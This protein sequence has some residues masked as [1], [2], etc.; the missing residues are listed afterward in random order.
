MGLNN[1]LEFIELETKYRVEGDFLY[2][3][4]NLV[5]ELPGLEEFIYVESKDVYYVNKNNDFVRYR[6]S[7]NKTDKRSEITWKF[8]PVGALNNIKRKE[9]NWRVDET[10]IESI[11]EGI[12]IE[13]FVKNFSINKLVHIYKFND[14]TLPFYT[15]QDD[16][17]SLDHFIEIEV[18]EELIK[19]LTEEQ[20]F[21]I[22]RK[23]ED[24]LAP[25]G[26]NSNKRLKKSLFEMYRK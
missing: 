25:I 13:G 6:F 14:A 26:I 19:S 18:N 12:R 10:P 15:V 1:S 24:L 23:Y 3:F 16:R 11:E 5:Q 17:G 21:D 4:K 9:I 7:P 8:K 2:T 20:A 22:I